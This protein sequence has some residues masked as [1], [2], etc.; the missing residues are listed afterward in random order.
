MALLAIVVVPA[1]VALLGMIFGVQVGMP[2]IQVA[3]FVAV[4][5]LAPLALG[6]TVRRLAPRL[7]A[8]AQEAVGRGAMTL[9]LVACVP[10]FIAVWPALAAI[11]GDGTLAV[12]ALVAAVALVGGHL[13]GGPEPAD[14]PVL[15]VT[16]ATRHPGLALL[17][18]RAN[19]DQESAAAAIL[20]FLL[21]G[22]AVGLPYQVLLARLP[23]RQ[24][25]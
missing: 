6:M 5:V 23:R 10:V 3:R 24:P 22:I 1:S 12:M 8:R 13:L 21:V 7:A 17:V 2:P 15:A 18:A 25:S 11:A 19:T 16:A 4:T 20:A 9:L 14:R